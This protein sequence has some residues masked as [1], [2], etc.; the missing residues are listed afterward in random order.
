M[1]DNLRTPTRKQ[2]LDGEVEHHA[3]YIA[4]AK[5]MGVSY[6]KSSDEDFLLRVARGCEDPEN[7][8]LLVP[9]REKDTRAYSLLPS[10]NSAFEKHGDYP[11]LAGKVCVVMAAAI[12]A[13]RQRGMIGCTH[14]GC[15]KTATHAVELPSDLAL[16]PKRWTCGEHDEDK[17]L[18]VVI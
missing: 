15:H 18:D 8:G 1:S 11:S 3:Y 7:A 4:L 13:A 6:L 2:Y 5:S 10:C 16:K 17:G 9:L 14:D 12:E